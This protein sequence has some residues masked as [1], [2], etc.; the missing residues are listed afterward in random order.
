MINSNDLK[1]FL[2]TAKLLHLTKASKELGLSQPALSHCIKRLELEVGE[3]LFIRRKDGLRLTKSGEFLLLKGQKIFDELVGVADYLKTGRSEARQT[4]TLGLHPSVAA[5]SLPY[6]M[7]ELQ[8]IN[9]KFRFG[10]SREVTEWIQS[11]KVDCGVVINPFPHSNLII[12]L[13]DSDKFTLWTHRKNTNHHRIFFDPQ[14]HQTHSLLR[15]LEKKGIIF[16]EQYEIPN[17]ELIAKFVYEGSGIGILPEKV[18][19]NYHPE[20]TKIYNSDIKP[21]QDKI[22]FVYSTENKRL[23]SLVQLKTAVKKV[24]AKA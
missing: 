9:L 15:Q 5:Y 11:G 17:L 13:V 4:L 19:K 10:L 1:S 6:I 22:C 2:T 14:L 24:L 23:A 12:S 16:S 21:F 8:N 20:L 18:V 3:E 7:N